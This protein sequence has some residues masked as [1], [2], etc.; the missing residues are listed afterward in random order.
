MVGVVRGDVAL[1]V[2]LCEER[3]REILVEKALDVGGLDVLVGAPA[4]AVAPQAGPVASVV[5]A[6]DA[7]GRNHHRPVRV[8]RGPE[9]GGDVG[10]IVG[11]VVDVHVAAGWL[12]QA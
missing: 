1:P 9:I 5:P 2:A 12:V 10:V 6:D 8:H 11:R 4:V 7:L 3:P